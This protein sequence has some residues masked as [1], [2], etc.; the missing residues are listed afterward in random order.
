MTLEEV[1]ADAETSFGAEQYDD[2]LRAYAS[3]VEV[4]PSFLPARK[5][6]GDTLLA[7]DEVEAA[8]S[9]Y[10]AVAWRYVLQGHPLL[11]LAV[12]KR[13]VDL[14]PAYE[15]LVHIIAE[16]YSAASD[17]VADI[18]S[19]PLPSLADSSMAPAEIDIEAED[20][21]RRVAERAA[22]TDQS[23]A[24]PTWLPAI[25]LFSALTES[26]FTKVLTSLQL[27]RFVEG[28]EI[29]VEGDDGDALFIVA[30]GHVNI[31][32]WVDGRVH[33][34]AQLGHG[35][36]FGEMA[37]IRRVPRSAT[38]VAVGDVEIFE[39]TRADL[40]QHADE[41]ESVRRA[42]RAFTRSR[43]LANLAA[44]SPLFVDLGPEDRRQLL[45]EFL[46]QQVG[47]GDIL[48][49]EG[50]PGR[51]LFLIVSGEF[52]V[53]TAS[54]AIG[55]LSAGEIFGEMSLL[56][57]SAAMASV[58]ADTDGEVLVLPKKSFWDVLRK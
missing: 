30:E 20:W 1:Y 15:D 43:L 50:G 4:E 3:I 38:A 12:A 42:L 32:R 40:E 55:R 57:D 13:L 27:R 9:V 5:R 34:M 10:R 16:L 23:E 19:L 53:R 21:A 37:L 11:G 52:D 25:P 54:G 48:L 7:M 47:A 45:A 24:A 28:E 6:V 17:R 39:L 8:K 46:A 51:G 58:L 29:V 14:D 26:A 49:E 2:A 31:T 44:T 56:H 22:E 35:A 36:V 18:P 41:L 33:I